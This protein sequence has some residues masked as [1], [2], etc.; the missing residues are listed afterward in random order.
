MADEEV[1]FDF[2]RLIDRTKSTSVKWNRKVLEKDFGD[3]D[4]IPLWVADMDFKAP[5][6]IINAIIEQAEFGIYGYSIFPPSF[7]ESIISWFKRR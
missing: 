5:E 6:P 3:P 7:Y 4:L 2:D 1:K